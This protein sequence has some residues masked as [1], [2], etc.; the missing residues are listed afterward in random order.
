MKLTAHTG[1][2][3]SSPHHLAPDTPAT[4]IPSLEEALAVTEETVNGVRRGSLAVSI[5]NS[6]SCGVSVAW[7][8]LEQ[9]IPMSAVRF[10]PCPPHKL[11]RDRSLRRPFH[12]GGL[13]YRGRLCFFIAPAVRRGRWSPRRRDSLAVIR[14]GRWRAAPRRPE[15]W[16]GPGRMGGG[17]G[18]K[19]LGC[20]RVPGE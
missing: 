18:P 10:C 19:F 15:G 1:A 4:S 13:D 16:P 11:S 20:T 3:V 12:R 6:L 14:R 8:L 9:K 2:P 5:A 7:K 17:R